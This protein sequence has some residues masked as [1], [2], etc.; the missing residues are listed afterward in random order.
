MKTL[1]NP[2]KGAITLKYPYGNIY[3]LYGENI[4]LYM[5]AIGSHGHNGIDIA[6]AEGTPIQ[7]SKGQVIEVKD[8]P[9][10]YGKHVRILTDPDDQGVYYELV[11]GHLR[12][13]IVKIG[14]LVDDGQQI[15]EMS[16]T[17]FVISGNTPYWNNAPKG[18]GV[19]LHWGVRECSINPTAWLTTYSSGKTAYLKDYENGLFG[20]IDPQ[21][22][23]AANEIVAI[24]LKLGFLQTI[25]NLYQRLK[26]KVG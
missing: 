3:Q 14:D 19:H 11:F 25:L 20:Y 15:A 6:M 4:A 16:N 9:E 26:S 7:A 17:G 13:I 8:T 22:F 1:F 5:A 18:R 24:K 10:G 12:N 23:L 2:V 21:L